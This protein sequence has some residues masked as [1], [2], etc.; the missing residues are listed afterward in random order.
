MKELFEGVYELDGRIVTE[1]L[2]PGRRVYGEPLR[3]EGGKEYR[4]WNPTRSKISAAIL[5]GL[6]TLPLK[7]DSKILYLG[8]AS[9]TTAS[10]LSDIARNGTIFCVENASVPMGGLID[11]CRNR[12][13]MVP[14]M[15]DANMPEGYAPLLE[16]VDFIYQDVAQKN[17][18]EILVKNSKVYLNDEGMAMLALK[19]RSIDSARDAGSV[20]LD[21][22]ARLK[23]HFRIIQVVDLAPYEKDHAMILVEK[24][25]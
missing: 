7:A 19:A 9:G 14:V 21:E 20:I 25:H 24:K 5:N 23:E 10:H 17:Q 4:Q 1:N 13:N 15:G 18:A 11:I 12:R 6:E 8:A 3:K 16:K 22:T 2:T